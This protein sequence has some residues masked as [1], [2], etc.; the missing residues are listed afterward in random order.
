V[1]ELRILN[2]LSG[3]IEPGRLTLVLG[4]P[5]C[6]KTTLLRTLAGRAPSGRASGRVT[7]N[8]YTAAEFCAPRSIAY[9]AQSD[10][11]IATLT[12]RET[13][14]FAHAIQAGSR[15]SEFRPGAALRDDSS[16]GS[17]DDGKAAPDVDAL[18]SLMLDGTGRADLFLRMFGLQGAADTVVGNAMLRGVSGGERKRLSTV[19]QLMAAQRV[20][21]LDEISTGLVRLWQQAAHPGAEVQV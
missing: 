11:H 18:A 13:A 7:W 20:Q 1:Q 14:K 15:T 19:E 21:V 10:T 17:T 3:R 12:T 2:D 8:G 5:S 6:G 9:V 16:N 4:P